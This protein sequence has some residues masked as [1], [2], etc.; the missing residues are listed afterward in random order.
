M[1]NELF[2][3]YGL[4]VLLPDSRLLKN[5]FSNVIER[6]LLE[7]FSHTAVQETVAAF[8]A[9]YKVQASGRELNLFYLTDGARERIESVNGQWSI[10]N[11]EVK[12]SREQILQ[13]LKEFPERFSPNVILRPVFQET[14]LPNVAFIGGG[15]EIAYWLELKKVFEAAAVPYPMLVLR[16]SF[17]LVD[18]KSD[19]LINKLQLSNEAI[20]QPEF[21][22]MN[23]LVKRESAHQLSLENEKL[24][25]AEVYE[26]LK[27]IAGKVDVTLSAHTAALHKKS[28]QRIEILEKKMLRAEKEKFEAQQRQL[29]KL[30]T[31]LF[32]NSNLQE[33]VENFMLQYAKSGKAF[34]QSIYENSLSLEQEFV[35]LTE[36]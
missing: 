21:D 6:E 25:L 29:H 32:P 34:I 20:F 23:M 17:L 26:Q 2:A 24:K 35:I 27:E 5:A 19:A 3:E 36:K 13:E 28:L 8:P 9:K 7:Q 11:T 22:L 4:L 30:K 18:E 31:Q 10:V 15:G 16:N 1:V 12:F 14:I 33:R